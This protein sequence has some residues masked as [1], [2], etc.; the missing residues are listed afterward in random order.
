MTRSFANPHALR[1]TYLRSVGKALTVLAQTGDAVQLDNAIEKM[2]R[3]I[4][5]AQNAPA[6]PPGQ[7]ESPQGSTQD[8]RVSWALWA[9]GH[10]GVGRSDTEPLPFLLALPFVP[11]TMK[12]RALAI[13]EH[14]MRLCHQEMGHRST[15]QPETWLLAA[16]VPGIDAFVNAHE[17]LLRSDPNVPLS[18]QWEGAWR[19][20][21]A[22]GPDLVS[23]MTLR[24]AFQGPAAFDMHELEH[25]TFRSALAHGWAHYEW[26]ERWP[27]PYRPGNNHPASER[28]RQV[29]LN[30]REPGSV[31][32][33]LAADGSEGVL[34]LWRAHRADWSTWVNPA[35][36]TTVWRSALL[37]DNPAMIGRWLKDDPAALDRPVPNGRWVHDTDGLGNARRGLAATTWNKRDLDDAL[38]HARSMG[39]A[40]RLQAW[41]DSPAPT[42]RETVWALTAHM[43]PTATIF[44]SMYRDGW[45]DLARAIEAHDLRTELTSDPTLN[46]EPL[47]SKARAR[48]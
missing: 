26:L 4:D 11:T 19:N 12:T 3:W 28:L 36:G 23:R 20:L 7:E 6:K 37:S 34:D 46:V 18:D 47:S 1:Q 16:D 25:R 42:L 29:P 2:E 8:P 31:L 22:A 41:W 48:L 5:H 17:A 45:F 35:T 14:L 44:S 27:G 39:Q 30:A 43:F 21:M 10:T 33:V 15:V 38:D 13:A 9:S 24:V 40:A 32:D